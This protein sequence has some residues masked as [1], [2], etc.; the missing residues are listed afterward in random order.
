MNKNNKT[1]NKIINLETLLNSI[2]NDIKKNIQKTTKLIKKVN[3]QNKF[4]I[5]KYNKIIQVLS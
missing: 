1:L 5:D 3:D 2:D 4:I